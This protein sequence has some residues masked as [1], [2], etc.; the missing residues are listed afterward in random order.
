M[1]PTNESEFRLPRAPIVEAVLDIDCD[2]PSGQKLATLEAPARERLQDR[3]PRFRA[4][5]IQE[6]HVEAKQDELPSVSF[7]HHVGALQF[8]Q[9]D[10]RQLV[11]F[12]PEGFSFNRLAPYS[13]LDEYLPEIER[14]WGAFVELGSPLQIRMVRLRYINRML[15]PAPDGKLDLT[16]FLN[17]APRLPD[18][19]TLALVGFLSQQAAVELETGNHVNLVLASQPLEGQKVPT[20]LDL[21]V[22]A[23][24]P[25]E[26]KN[27]SWILDRIVALR[28]LK[29]RVFRSTL[30]QK[31][32]NLFQ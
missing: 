6:H 12:R 13:S 15:L 32:L 24:G 29:N 18:E 16:A 21:S 31:C 10:E 23:P 4:Q 25:M 30:T 3:Y 27:W 1:P 28:L 22:A 5:L 14:T 7:R 11:Q 26:P 9:N 19:R 17:V 20:I 2:M 8:L